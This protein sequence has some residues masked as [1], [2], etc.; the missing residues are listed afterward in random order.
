MKVALNYEDS[1]PKEIKEALKILEDN[2]N[3]GLITYENVKSENTIII[4]VDDEV[5]ESN[6]E[7]IQDIYVQLFEL[8]MVEDYDYP[9]DTEFDDDD[10]FY[11]DF[12]DD[13]Y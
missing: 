12:N 1:S 3:N 5:A 13:E 4:T 9:L 6:D 10:D 8:S 11:N 7:D 2:Q